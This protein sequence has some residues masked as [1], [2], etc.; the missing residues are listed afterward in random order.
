MLFFSPLSFSCCH[1]R[2]CSRLYVSKQQADAA[3]KLCFVRRQIEE[4]GKKKPLNHARLVTDK[5]IPTSAI[6]S[7]RKRWR[8][9]ARH[10]PAVLGK[11]AAGNCCYQ[12]TDGSFS[13]F[14]SSVSPTRPQGLL[15]C[16]PPRRD[17]HKAKLLIASLQGARLDNASHPF[18]FRMEGA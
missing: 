11:L 18:F 3:S 14:F 16:Q 2:R 9:A 6:L 13:V 8:A 10:A 5:W 12:T 1:R 15:Y 7:L 4:K 17:L